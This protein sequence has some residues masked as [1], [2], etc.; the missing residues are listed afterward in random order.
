MMRQSDFVI[1]AARPTAPAAPSAPVVATNGGGAGF[2]AV[3]RQV[4]HEVADFIAHGDG[5]HGAGG[6]AAFAPSLEAGAALERGRAAGAGAAADAAAPG[7]SAAQRQFLE[8]IRPWAEQAGQRLGVAPELVS[9]H[10]ALESGWGR[11]PLRDGNGGDTNNLF[12]LKA[13]GQWRGA[14]ANAATTEFARGVAQKTSADFRSYPDQA[15]A[16]RDY[17]ALLLDNPRYR[18][19]LNTGADAQAFAAGLARGG[20]ASDPAYAGKL[21]RLAQRLQ[22][23]AL[24]SSD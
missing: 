9:A 4:Q 13:G 3:F 6:G 5:A 7:E 17:T 11:H 21:A 22:Q 20:Y 12:S 23:G 8:T 16:F 2:G 19:A 15:S 14:V 10:A 24:Q 1:A 18:G